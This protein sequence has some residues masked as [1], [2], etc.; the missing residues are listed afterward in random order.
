MTN[1]SHSR[2]GSDY[3]KNLSSFMEEEEPREN[4]LTI[5]VIES[6]VTM[7][8]LDPI[9][10]ETIPPLKLARML[11]KLKDVLVIDVR[12]RDHEGGN[13]P[14]SIHVKTADVVANPGFLIAE[15]RKRKV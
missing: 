5:S 2:R 10:I 8:D 15:I 7:Q 12:G 14:G 1:Y 6:G 3:K 4:E 13:V 11:E 9:Q